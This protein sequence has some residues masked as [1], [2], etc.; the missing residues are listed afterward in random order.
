MTDAEVIQGRLGWEPGDVSQANPT[1]LQPHPKNKEI[2]G[3][4]QS[5]DALDDSFRQSVAEK[6]VLEPLVITRGKQI[7]SGHRRWLA[8]KAADLDT[9]PVRYTEFDDEL[10][11]REALVE[12]NRQREKTPG[13]LVNEFEEIVAIEKKRAKERKEANLKQN[14]RSGN[15]STSDA[16]KAREKAAEKM[17]SDVSGRTLEKGK[18]VKDKAESEDEPESV[19]E[20]AKEAWDGLQ[21]GDESFNSAYEEVKQA[22]R[23]AKEE[24]ERE[25]KR[26]QRKKAFAEADTLVTIKTGD[27]RDVGESLD[28]ES[29]DA[30][31]TDP[32]YDDDH[33]EL[34]TA[35]SELADR[36]L[37]PGGFCIAYSGKAHLP[38][39]Y[40]NLS[41]SLEY[42]WT[43]V[44]NHNGP[45]AKIFSRKLRTGYKP[46]LVFT[47]PPA[48]PQEE[49]VTDVIEGTGR[50]KDDHDWQQAEGEAAALIERFT[51]IN[52]RVLDPMCGSG[53]V[54][55]A[56]HRLQRQ[57]VLF[58]KDADATDSARRRVL[59]ES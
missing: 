50:E 9:V 28:S 8:A 31:I 48:N 11:E 44:V 52:D 18:K 2:Y 15:V 20:T 49:F 38:A 10:A 23:E 57:C 55:V 32:P 30:I 6:G 24:Q 3:D 27:F 26:E 58:D 4:T 22:E 45:G 41:S 56:C 37:K 13:Q 59:N 43:A 36:V 21:S 14:D 34:W 39:V 12:F 42:Y 5:P 40:E 17:D 51:N 47:K 54:G 29:V 7:I 46:V 19:R 16:G 1:N 25:S 53:T 35:L 33:L